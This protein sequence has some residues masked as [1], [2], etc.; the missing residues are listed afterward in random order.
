[1]RIVEAEMRQRALH[2]D[3]VAVAICEHRER[4]SFPHSSERVDSEL[5][6]FRRVDQRSRQ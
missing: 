5:E 6:R 2:G 4:F 1:M 3:P